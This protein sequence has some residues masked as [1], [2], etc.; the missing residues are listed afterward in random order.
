MK[1]FLDTADTEFILKYLPT[2]TIDGV[3]TNPS[4]I[5]KSGRDPEEVYKELLEAEPDGAARLQSVSM[6]VSGTYEEMLEEGRRLGKKFGEFGTIKVP[7]TKDGLAVCR[8]LSNEDIDVNVTLIFTLSQA[9]LALRAGARYISPFVGRLD[10]QGGDGT[11]LIDQIR[12]MMCREGL[13]NSQIIAASIRTVAQAEASWLAGAHII[14]VPPKVY[15]DMHNHI[16][17][18]K[19]LEIFDNDWKTVQSR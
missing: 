13:H 10:D 18:D 6:E 11:K 16:L 19:G 8:V 7:C 15:E 2:G 14:T 12:E 9:I 1:I 4:L 17:T 3:T 5:C